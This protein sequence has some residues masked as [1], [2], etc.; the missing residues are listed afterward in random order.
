MKDAIN[1]SH[2]KDSCSL[3]CI[4]AMEL[5]YGT[6][7]ILYFCLCNAFKYLWRHKFKNGEEDL[8]KA[9]WY[10]HKAEELCTS[11][12]TEIIFLHRIDALKKIIGG[13]RDEQI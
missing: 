12:V 6:E 2:Y 7:G 11:N 1:P 9:E 5:A 3:E 13:K 4:E 8:N 10:I